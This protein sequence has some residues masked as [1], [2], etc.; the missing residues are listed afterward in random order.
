MLLMMG[1]SCAFASVPLVTIL[2]FLTRDASLIWL[3]LI[4][5]D[6]NVCLLSREASFIWICRLRSRVA[7][8]L[9]GEARITHV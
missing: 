6:A 3:S 4:R 7:C 5:P 1:N 8:Y 2:S 9:F